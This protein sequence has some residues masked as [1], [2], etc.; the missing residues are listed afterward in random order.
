MGRARP[1]LRGVVRDARAHRPRGRRASSGSGVGSGVSVD[2]ARPARCRSPCCH[3]VARLHIP[4]RDR[5]ARG[6][7]RAHGSPGTTADASTWTRSAQCRARTLAV[8]DRRRRASSHRS[9]LDDA[10]VLDRRVPEGGLRIGGPGIGP[11]RGARRPSRDGPGTT[12]LRALRK[13]GRRHRRRRPVRVDVAR[14]S[15]ELEALIARA[16]GALVVGYSH[17]PGSSGVAQR[18][19]PRGRGR[20]AVTSSEPGTSAT[21]STDLPCGS[22]CRGAGATSRSSGS[23]TDK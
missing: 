8:P 6:L 3:G 15:I 12:C 7:R 11:P 17:A 2:R 22:R 19:D 18:M 16:P 9:V 4:R 5:P 13:S 14:R 1:V 20:S 23:A 10:V 21:A